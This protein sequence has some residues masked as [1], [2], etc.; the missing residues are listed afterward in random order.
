MC[1]SKPCSRG[2][3]QLPCGTVMALTA[4]IMA[5]VDNDN[6]EILLSLIEEM[7]SIGCLM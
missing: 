6:G 5:P 4:V 3:G 7:P 1:V 2:K